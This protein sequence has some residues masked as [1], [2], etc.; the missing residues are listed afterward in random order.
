MDRRNF[1]KATGLGVGALLLPFGHRVIAAEALL[2]RID[3]A[4]KK[5]LADVALG[6]AKDAGATYCDVR[7]GK[8]LNQFVVTREDKVQNV[9]NT[10][11]T[12]VG[13]RVIAKGTWGFAAT[14]ELTPDAVARAAK[15]A[16]A[17]AKANSRL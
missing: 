2:D 9:V 15:Q 12:G 5:R 13:I 1:V 17:I 8:Y 16:V 7:I 3:P 4:L 11:T 6:A 14:N 10:E